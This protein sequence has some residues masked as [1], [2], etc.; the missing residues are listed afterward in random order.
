MRKTKRTNIHSARK[1]MGE[2]SENLG[3]MLVFGIDVELGKER[4]KFAISRKARAKI[5]TEVFQRADAE[6]EV[7]ASRVRK[8]EEEEFVEHRIVC[9]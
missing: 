3:F 7:R 2:W 1:R 8:V 4:L 5:N 6:F 9:R